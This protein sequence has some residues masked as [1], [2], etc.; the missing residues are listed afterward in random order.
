MGVLESLD[1]IDK[2]V[3]SLVHRA[4]VGM[5]EI[6]ILPFALIFNPP[7]IAM[8]SVAMYNFLVFIEAQHA[9]KERPKNEDQM[10]LLI[11]YLL[12]VIV[13]VLVTT[14]TKRLGARPRPDDPTCCDKNARNAR[15]IN[16]RHHETNCSMPSGDTA[17]SA[18]FVTFLSFYLPAFWQF[19]GGTKFSIKWV[20]CIAFAR[21]FYHCH[22]VG[23]TIIGAALGASV[24]FVLHSMGIEQVSQIAAETLIKALA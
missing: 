13:L 11:N 9:E 23:D 15:Y 20:M 4:Q 24:A 21:I 17:Q 1:S 18:I 22:Y 7:G 5:G 3:S 8:L 19:L 2:S 12:H 14:I 16:L 10:Q 6:I